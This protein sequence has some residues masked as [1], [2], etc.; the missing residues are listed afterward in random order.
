MYLNIGPDIMLSNDTPDPFERADRIFPVE[1]HLGP[2]RATRDIHERFLRLHASEE[3]AFACDRGP[4]LDRALR[5][6][7]S[8]VIQ[9]AHDKNGAAF[10]H[11]F[12]VDQVG[13]GIGPLVLVDVLEEV[14]Q[15]DG[16]LFVVALLEVQEFLAGAVEIV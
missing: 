5:G 15:Q 8:R 12:S 10:G 9:L 16:M 11:G 14:G 1:F 4:D 6:S 13:G 7:V 3:E 2:A